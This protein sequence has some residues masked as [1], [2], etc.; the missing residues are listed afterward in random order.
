MPERRK[1][2]GWTQRELE[3]AAGF[4]QAQIR[5]IEADKAART[6]PS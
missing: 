2:L 5:R 4:T 1:N 3:K 6:L